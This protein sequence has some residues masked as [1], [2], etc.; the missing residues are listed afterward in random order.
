V[1]TASVKR[2]V[3]ACLGETEAELET[4][5]LAPIGVDPTAWLPDEI[6]WM[7]IVQVLAKG[8]CGRVCRR[9]YD[10]CA[11]AS[12]TKAAWQWRCAATPVEG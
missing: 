8:G 11:G 6:L 5:V 10:V 7:I 12:A 3:S 9:C 2:C 1:I 4:A